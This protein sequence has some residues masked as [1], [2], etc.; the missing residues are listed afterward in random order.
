MNRNK[1]AE[2]NVGE[3]ET[4]TV[5]TI[6]DLTEKVG[7]WSFRTLGTLIHRYHMILNSISCLMIQRTRK[8]RNFGTYSSL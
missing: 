5:K 3:L 2:R 6:S 7:S 1:K 4:N 8:S